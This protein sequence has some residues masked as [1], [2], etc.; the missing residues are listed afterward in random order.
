MHDL[1]GSRERSR[2][3]MDRCESGWYVQRPRVLVAP[4]CGFG[5]QTAL[6]SISEETAPAGER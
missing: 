3:R 6:K 4:T 2:I 5:D 1:L